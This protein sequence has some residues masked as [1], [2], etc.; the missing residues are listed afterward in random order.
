[1][2]RASPPWALV[3][4]SEPPL[5]WGVAVRTSPSGS[6]SLAS[7]GRSAER[8]GRTPKLSSAALGGWFSSVRS[9]G[10]W[11]SEVLAES[12]FWSALS[13]VWAVLSVQSSMRTRSSLGSHTEP[14][15]RSLSTMASRLTRKTGAEEA[16][17]LSSWAVSV[18]PPNSPEQLRTNWPEP[19]QA[20]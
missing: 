17:S 7:T 19:D 5:S 8:P 2:R 13:S 14:V 1:M 16:A 20:A 11:E 15:S 10:V 4:L 6:E 3:A 18:P 12:S 9:G